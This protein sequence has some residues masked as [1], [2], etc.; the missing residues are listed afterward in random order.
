MRWARRALSGDSFLRFGAGLA[1]SGSGAAL[2]A[3]RGA[4]FWAW[5]VR[6]DEERARVLGPLSA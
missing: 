1:E 4:Q 3:F 6:G 5:L 2:R